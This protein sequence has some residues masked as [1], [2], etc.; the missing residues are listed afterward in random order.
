[1]M[2]PARDGEKGEG[3]EDWRRR[4]GSQSGGGGGGGRRDEDG[5]GRWAADATGAACGLPWRGLDTWLGPKLDLP[6]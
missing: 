3:V 1:M 5:G 6:I 4:A 2:L